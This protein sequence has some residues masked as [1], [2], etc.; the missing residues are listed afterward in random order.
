MEPT[1]T[2]V[3]R[4]EPEGGY[5]VLVPA[6]PEIVSFGESL[7]EAQRMAGDAIRCVLLSC[8]EDGEPIPEETPVVTVPEDE[9]TGP[10]YICRVSS[11]PSSPSFN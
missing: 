10:L 5:T 6:L 2:V 11:A 8:R 4:A 9:R 3:L 7:E 1:Y